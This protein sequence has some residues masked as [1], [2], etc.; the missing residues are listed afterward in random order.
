LVIHKPLDENIIV[1]TLGRFQA[2]KGDNAAE[3][4]IHNLPTVL[5]VGK[6]TYIACRARDIGLTCALVV[7]AIGGGVGVTAIGYYTPFMIAG[8][9]IMAMG[10]G[11]LLLFKV[12][13]PIAMW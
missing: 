8:S 12:D 7:F 9:L 1:L 6:H 2:I 3:S 4:G 11:L 5:S 13:T 10:A